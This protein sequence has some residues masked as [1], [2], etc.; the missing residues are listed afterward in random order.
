MHVAILEAQDDDI[1][2]IFAICSLAFGETEPAWR[3]FFPN[4]WTEAGRK[5]GAERYLKTKQSD[6]HATYHK[7]V[8]T[9]TGEIV[10]FSIW[11]VY[12]NRL[13]DY[14]LVKVLR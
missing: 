6:P 13:L 10:G 2:R 7:A 14:T 11:T 8:D 4:H 9:D 12:Q 5:V 1:S 3:A